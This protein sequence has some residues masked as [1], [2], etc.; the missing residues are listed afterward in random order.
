MDKYFD[1]LQEEFGPPTAT[2]SVPT[3]VIETFRGKLPDKL[4]TYWREHGF[5][6]F[7]DG[8]FSLVNPDDYE[9]ELEAWIGDTRVVEYDAYYV[10]ARSGFGDL[11]LW[12]TKTGHKFKI[13][14]NHG[15]VLEL[16]GDSAEIATAGSDAALEGFIATKTA[17]FF[18]EKDVDREPLFDRAVKMLG[19]L[20]PDDIFAFEPALVAGGAARLENIVK[21]NVHV[22]L[23]VLA[24]FGQREI[25]DRQALTR[26]AFG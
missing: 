4:L 25:L 5:C 2:R 11:L 6:S 7:H 3:S 22:H 8:L 14:P 1:A 24:Q 20:G 15:W 16:D 17:K 12:G 23:N 9:A 26:K 19:P 10:I 21:R 18:D 13:R